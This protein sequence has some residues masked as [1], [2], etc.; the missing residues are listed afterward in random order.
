LTEAYST[1]DE[2]NAS[3]DEKWGTFQI[4]QRNLNEWSLISVGMRFQQDDFSEVM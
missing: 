2:N 3:I 1:V 4:G